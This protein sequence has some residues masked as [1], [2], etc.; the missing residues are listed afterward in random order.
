MGLRIGTGDRAELD[1][2][3]DEETERQREDEGRVAKGDGREAQ[4][5]KTCGDGADDRHSLL[6]ET[7]QPDQ[8]DGEGDHD[9]GTGEAREPALQDENEEKRRD[10]EG[11]RVEVRLREVL[12]DEVDL[13]E[14]GRGGSFQIRGASGSG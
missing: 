7:G 12:E 11:E 4:L 6:G 5:G 3:E 14:E 8:D 13:P 1:K 10:T 9:K 2:G